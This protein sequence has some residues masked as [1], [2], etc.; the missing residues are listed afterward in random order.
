[1]IENPSVGAMTEEMLNEVLLRNERNKRI[2]AE[3]DEA[4]AKRFKSARC[5]RFHSWTRIGVL[6]R[7]SMFG[8]LT[9]DYLH[10]DRILWE[11]HRCGAREAR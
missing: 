1:M 11:C 8:A 7:V 2:D 9:D 6:Q 3:R 4:N 5:W 10:S